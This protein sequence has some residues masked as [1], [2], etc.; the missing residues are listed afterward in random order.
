MTRRDA[1]R[2]GLLAIGSLTLLNEPGIAAD[3]Q[4]SVDI[5][6]FGG[7]AGKYNRM[8]Q[9]LKELREF[10]N[11]HKLKIIFDATRSS[12]NAYFIKEKEQG[13]A[14]KSIKEILREMMSYSDGC[15]YSS[16]KDCL[17]NIGGFLA[18]N[19]KELFEKRG[20]VCQSEAM[21]HKC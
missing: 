18:T 13:Y 17:V 14:D 8:L 7:G 5:T 12:E 6:S 2:Q 15:I 21:G 16:K 4:T 1:L 3:K 11:E 20:S 19:N 9:N 10:C